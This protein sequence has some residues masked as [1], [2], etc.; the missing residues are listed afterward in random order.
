[1]VEVLAE[2]VHQLIGKS[3]GYRVDVGGLEGVSEWPNSPSTASSL[4][5]AIGAASWGSGA[6][7]QRQLSRRYRSDGF[8]L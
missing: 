7:A 2:R 3:G 8:L 6:T 5:A 1:M 4:A